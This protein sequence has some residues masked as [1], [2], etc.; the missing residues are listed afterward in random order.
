MI[1]CEEA[2]H[3]CNKKQYKE[4]SWLE[5]F[6]LI[7][8]LLICKTCKTFSRKNA[9]LTTLCEQAE[10]RSLTQKEKQEMKR[11]LQG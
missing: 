3:I 7:L 1:S 11:Q 4:A 5:R 10:L 9:R 2:A 6:Q 8:H